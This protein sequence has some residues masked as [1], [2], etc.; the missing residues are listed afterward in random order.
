MNCNSVIADFWKFKGLTNVG[1]FLN[2]NVTY[3]HVYFQIIS[4]TKSIKHHFVR[5]AVVW[6]TIHKY[7]ICADNS[8]YGLII[9]VLQGANFLDK[10]ALQILPI[11]IALVSRCMHCVSFLRR[12]MLWGSNKKSHI[13]SNISSRVA[14]VPFFYSFKGQNCWHFII[15]SNISQMVRDR[16]NIAI[17]VR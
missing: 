13:N 6:K 17:V 2:I 16:A 3:W 1:L 12:P 4:S 5:N 9:T 15:L 14:Q 10:S 8:A 11:V 7:G